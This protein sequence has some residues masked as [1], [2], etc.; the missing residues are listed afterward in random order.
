[1]VE[2]VGRADDKPQKHTGC[3]QCIGPN[4]GFY[5]SFVCVENNHGQNNQRGY[6]KRNT[7]TVENRDLQNIHHKVKPCRCTY[8][9]RNNKNPCARFV[10]ALP[11]S[12]LQ[13][14]INRGQ[15]QPVIKWEQNISNDYI[16]NKIANR[17][18]Q[19]MKLIGTHSTWNRYESN[20]RKRSSYHAKGN[21]HPVGFSVSNEE[22]VVVTAF[23][24]SVS[25]PQQ[26]RKISNNNQQQYNWVHNL[27]FLSGANIVFVFY[28]GTFFRLPLPLFSLL[29][30]GK[31]APFKPGCS[32]F[33]E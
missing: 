16:T 3:L 12:L 23:S 31:R 1:M 28:L 5:A 9:S 21:Q 24:G 20:P 2:H 15:F 10:R 17:Y 18:L 25:H 13:I 27:S 33:I 19:I 30:Q 14:T 11:Q 32:V 29:V 26:K 6:K 8:Q 22:T 7:Q 4:N